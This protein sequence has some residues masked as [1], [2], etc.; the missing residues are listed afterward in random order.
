MNF[1]KN[2][3]AVENED[4]VTPNYLQIEEIQE[5]GD[6]VNPPEKLV[7]LGSIKE[8]QYVKIEGTSDNDCLEFVNKEGRIRKTYH[9]SGRKM[10]YIALDDGDTVITK[11]DIKLANKVYVAVIHKDE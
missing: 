8:G 10:D 5:G 9:R 1:E 6:L 3:N 11:I 7:L 4:F 2:G